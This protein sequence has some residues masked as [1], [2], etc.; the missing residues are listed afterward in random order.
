M[1][2][3]RVIV[4]W[5]DTRDS[6]LCQFH[7]HSCNV[8]TDAVTLYNYILQNPQDSESGEL[9]GC[10]DVYYVD[11]S[12]SWGQASSDFL[13]NMCR[14]STYTACGMPARLPGL[15]CTISRTGWVDRFRWQKDFKI[16]S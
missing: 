16:R 13:P 2:S 10:F 14:P 6:I 11:G 12:I 8:M 1:C 7:A 15:R 4:T 9:C 5:I 3:Q